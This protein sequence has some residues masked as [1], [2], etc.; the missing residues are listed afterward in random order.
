MFG[1]P[2]TL[3]KLNQVKLL[4][5]PTSRILCDPIL[6][7]LNIIKLSSGTEICITMHIP[8]CDPAVH[9]RTTFSVPRSSSETDRFSEWN[10]SLVTTQSS[11]MI[12]GK[13]K[14]EV[15]KDPTHHVGKNGE[16]FYWENFIYECSTMRHTKSNQ[17]MGILHA[18][19]KSNQHMGILHAFSKPNQHMGTPHA[20][21]NC[22]RETFNHGLSP[23]EVDW[24]DRKGEPTKMLKYTSS[25][26]MLMQFD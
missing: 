15:T 5:N 10:S 17:H 2:I 20:F 6:G 16:H 12:P 21:S 19:S 25:G 4:C 8:L 1:E 24:G 7:K 13:L 23:S 3:R 18:F 11:R 14:I 26:N 9:T 22:V